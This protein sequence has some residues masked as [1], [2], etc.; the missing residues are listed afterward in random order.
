MGEVKKGKALLRSGAK[1]NDLIYVSGV[2]GDAFLQ[3]KELQKLQNQDTGFD[4]YLH[5]KAQIALGL[6][7]ID[8]ANSAIDISDGL[9]Q[10]L[11]LICKSSDVGAKVYL[12]MIPTSVEDKTLELINSGDDYQICFTAS[13]NN[14]TKIKHI[15]ERLGVPITEIGKITNSKELILLDYEGNKME[16]GSGYSH[17]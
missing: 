3:L 16:L 17:F 4:A 11:N 5:P 15:S 2:I 10:D 14:S 6:E 7:L 12:S 8:I 1:E 13:E 9:I